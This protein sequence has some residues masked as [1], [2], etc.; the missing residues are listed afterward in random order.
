MAHDDGRRH[1]AT[2]ARA[3]WGRAIWIV[4]AL[5]TLLVVALIVVPSVVQQSIGPS[6]VGLLGAPA[7]ALAHDIEATA[8]TSGAHVATVSVDSAAAGG[9]ALRTGAL[10]AM[11]QVDTA[12]S[13]SV[14]VEQT[15]DSSVESVLRSAL[16]QSHLRATLEQAGVRRSRQR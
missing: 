7:Q 11:L 16:D 3:P 8:A 10:D 4:S 1:A 13:A 14:T 12:G 5:T 15:L 9:H 2:Q 6:T